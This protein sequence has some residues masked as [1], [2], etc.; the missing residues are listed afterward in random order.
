VLSG[1]KR[2]EGGGIRSAGVPPH[3]LRSVLTGP[4]TPKEKVP[5]TLSVGALTMPWTTGHPEHSEHQSDVEQCVSYAD[6]LVTIAHTYRH[7]H[8]DS[9]CDSGL[10]LLSTGMHLLVTGS[11]VGVLSL[12]SS[13]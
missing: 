1:W 8:A 9:D 4:S 12:I 11:A 13:M 6:E 10:G 2:T 7:H 3:T 5:P